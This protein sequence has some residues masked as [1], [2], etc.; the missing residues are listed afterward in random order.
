VR[1]LAIVIVLVLPLAAAAEGL[2]PRVAFTVEVLGLKPALLRLRDAPSGGSVEDQLAE[3][4]ARQDLLVE[5]DRLSLVIDSTIAR[6]QREQVECE[7]VRGLLDDHQETAILHWSVAALLVG[8]VLSIVGSA[9]QFNSQRVAF[10]GDGLI[11]GGGALGAALGVVALTR[12]D[13]GRLSG[14]IDSTML[15][16]L[17]GGPPDEDSYPPEVW[18]WLDTPPPGESMSVRAALIAKWTREQRLTSRA[19]IARLTEPLPSGS[20]VDAGLLGDRADMIA[21]VR[22][23]VAAVRVDLQTLWRTVASMRAEL[24]K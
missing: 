11:I 4:R 6:L 17:L 8:N 16:P 13:H 7:S 19:R 1:G 18:R 15:R 12:G 24:R 14:A 9:M 22:G 2:P 20:R 3:L 5:L 21:D 10:I 23:R